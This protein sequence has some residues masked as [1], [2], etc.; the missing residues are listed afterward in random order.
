M[1]E[2]E[3]FLPGGK[4]MQS[5][6][7]RVMIVRG[8]N[9]GAVDEAAATAY[10]A[11]ELRQA[12]YLFAFENLSK[13]VA[14][15]PCGSVALHGLGK[16]FTSVDTARQAGVV[17]SRGK[18]EVC[19]RAALEVDGQNF[20]AANDLGV[21]LAEDGRLEMAR[22]VLR[23]ALAVS[24]QPATWNNLATVHERLGESQ[25]AALARHE[26]QKLAMSPAA[27]AGRPI[28]PA[29]N[30]QWV[31]SRRFA[32]AARP[33]VDEPMRSAQAGSAAR[34][35]ARTPAAPQPAAVPVIE[36][37]RQPRRNS[38]LN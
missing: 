5:A 3:D 2:V 6:D 9:S 32:S 22:A 38:I 23:A 14:G 25:L 10:G 13:A 27:A 26:S 12:Y 8:H 35:G 21:L 11:A 4:A 31:D 1:T 15:E 7:E 29:H 30:V 16:V 34:S 18:A 17:D 33:Q 36:T 24:P 19:L 37:A 28:V 20:P